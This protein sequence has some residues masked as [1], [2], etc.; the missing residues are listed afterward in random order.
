MGE[1]LRESQVF[2]SG[3]KWFKEG[4]ENMEKDERSG[5]PRHHRTDENVMELQN[6][7]HSDRSLSNGVM[8]VQLNLDKE[9][10]IE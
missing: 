9:S 10:Y 2:L 4:H 7:V 3:H 5:C 1:E 8:V 6:L